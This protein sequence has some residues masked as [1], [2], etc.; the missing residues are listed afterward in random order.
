[1]KDSEAIKEL[2]FLFEKIMSCHTLSD[3]SYLKEY[4]AD[5]KTFIAKNKKLSDGSSLNNMTTRIETGPSL[6]GWGKGKDE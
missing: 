6:L 3:L 4:A 2:E 5:R 1:M